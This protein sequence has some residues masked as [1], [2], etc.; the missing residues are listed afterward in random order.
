MGLIS[1]ALSLWN[2]AEDAQAGLAAARAVLEAGASPIGAVRAFAT[3]TGTTLDDVVL[4]ELEVGLRLALGWAETVL[5]AAVA[6][7]EAAADPR[8]KT[9]LDQIAK[10]V[11]DDAYV[12]AVWRARVRVWLDET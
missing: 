1:A 2:A 9:A 3:A 7:S 4:A 8:V 10:T 6:V 12:L 5:I 11:G